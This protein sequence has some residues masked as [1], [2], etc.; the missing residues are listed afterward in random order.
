MNFSRTGTV[1][2]V[3]RV[4]LPIAFAA[5]L[6]HNRALPAARPINGLPWRR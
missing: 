2:G 6:C 1:E 4:P 3:M 5:A